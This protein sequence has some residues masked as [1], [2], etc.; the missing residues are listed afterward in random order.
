VLIDACGASAAWAEFPRLIRKQGTAILYGFGEERG[1]NASLDQLQWRGAS[2]VATCGASGPL[3]TNGRPALY[4]EALR[5]IEMGNIDVAPLITNRYMNFES[6]P[7]AL[8]EDPAASGYLKG[9]LTPH[10]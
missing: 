4:A 10:S 8:G 9:V 6:L 5:A 1:T 7:T 3:D 2:L